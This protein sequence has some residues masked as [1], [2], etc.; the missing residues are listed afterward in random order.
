M[1]QELVV[2]PLQKVCVA[3]GEVRPAGWFVRK[4]GG[5]ASRCRECMRPVR[6]RDAAIRRKRMAGAER[7]TARDLERLGEAQ[8]WRCAV[9]GCPIRHQYHLDHKRPLAKGGRHRLD[10]L[11]LL[12]PR[13][14]LAKGSRMV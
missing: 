3:C 5:L 4:R 7:V 6:A 11:Q 8:G 14:N 13:D 10:N 9:C 12:C 2:G 1:S